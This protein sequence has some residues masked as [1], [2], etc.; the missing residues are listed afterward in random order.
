MTAVEIQ[1]H[2]PVSGNLTDIWKTLRSGGYKASKLPSWSQSWGR[3]PSCLR[4]HTS[5]LNLHLRVAVPQFQSVSTHR[6]TRKSY[7]NP[8]RQVEKGS[9]QIRKLRLRDLTTAG[10]QLGWGTRSDPKSSNLKPVL[11]EHSS[12]FPVCMLKYFH[13]AIYVKRNL[14]THANIC[15]VNNDKLPPA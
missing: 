3:A 2:Y 8:A 14:Y 1:Q 6:H 15:I 7:P 11:P 12:F 13:Y 4:Q 5:L 10:R 9:C